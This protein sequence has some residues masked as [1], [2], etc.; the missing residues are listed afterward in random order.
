MSTE[1]EMQDMVPSAE[2][3]KEEEKESSSFTGIEGYFVIPEWIPTFL[4]DPM[5]WIFCCFGCCIKP[6][7]NVIRIILGTFIYALLFALLI[8][9]IVILFLD[10]RQDVHNG[11]MLDKIWCAVNTNTADMALVKTALGIN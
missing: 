8:L 7:E 9:G 5:T 6:T 10:W 4:R 3:T 2:V 1:I 11:D